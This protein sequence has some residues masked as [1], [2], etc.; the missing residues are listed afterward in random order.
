MISVEEDRQHFWGDAT[1]LGEHLGA[2][3]AVRRVP[4]WLVSCAERAASNASRWQ[5]RRACD[6]VVDVAENQ[7]DA[8]VDQ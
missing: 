4:A 7:S 6:E 2:G 5:P 1:T 3:V 8:H